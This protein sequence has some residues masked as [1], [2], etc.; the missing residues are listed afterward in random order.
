MLT[1]GDALVGSFTA[2][3]CVLALD[4]A[5]IISVPRVDSGICQ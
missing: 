3:V 4:D 2:P 1:T 5:G